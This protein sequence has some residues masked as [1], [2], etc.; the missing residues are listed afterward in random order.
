[1]HRLRTILTLTI[2][3]FFSLAAFEKGKL[4]GK[5]FRVNGNTVEIMGV[6]G[7]KPPTQGN[8]VVETS[9]GLVAVSI[10]EVFHTKV[11][12][13]TTATGVIAAGNPVYATED[14]SWKNYPEKIIEGPGEDK[15]D[16]VR[17]GR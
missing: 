10:S 5:V 1:M 9:A 3:S 13:R 11:K 14:T 16:N 8:L 4:V 2:F 7:Q 17:Y 15:E 6:A 12:A